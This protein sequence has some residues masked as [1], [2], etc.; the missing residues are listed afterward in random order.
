[1]IMD[2]NLKN[3]IKAKIAYFLTNFSLFSRVHTD[4]MNP[5]SKLKGENYVRQSVIYY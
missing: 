1:M 5:F 2:L 4:K 3:R